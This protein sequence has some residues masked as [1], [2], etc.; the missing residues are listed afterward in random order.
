MTE[1]ERSPE[2]GQLYYT[3]G[4]KT[5]LAALIAYLQIFVTKRQRE[6][7]DLDLASNPFCELCRSD[8]QTKML[9]G[10]DAAPDAATCSWIDDNGVALFMAR[11]QAG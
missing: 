1:A 10:I 11:D 7:E 8:I 2:L 9:F 6:I 5:T 4:C 3:S